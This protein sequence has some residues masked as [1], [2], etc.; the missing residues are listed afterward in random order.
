MEIFIR[1][2]TAL[3]VI[4]LRFQKCGEVDF[5]EGLGVCICLFCAHQVSTPSTQCFKNVIF[6][7]VNNKKRLC[8]RGQSAECVFVVCMHQ[9]SMC[10]WTETCWQPT[11]VIAF[12]VRLFA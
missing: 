3:L 8:S 10:W 1:I 11:V 5:S 7:R 4:Y 9:D 2:Q 6:N 12:T